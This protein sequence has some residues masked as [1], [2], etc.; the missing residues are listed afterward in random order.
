MKVL[1]VYTFYNKAS[2]RQNYGKKYLE[3]IFRNFSTLLYATDIGIR[4]KL[5]KDLE[6]LSKVLNRLT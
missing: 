4:Q 1:S 3:I 5:G 6:D 2:I